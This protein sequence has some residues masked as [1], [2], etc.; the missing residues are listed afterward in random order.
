MITAIN[1]PLPEFIIVYS[2][3]LADRQQLQFI[4]PDGVLVRLPM[5]NAMCGPRAA[6]PDSPNA[7]IPTSPSFGASQRRV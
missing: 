2:D 3:I 5:W 1:V 7:P 6:A 4:G